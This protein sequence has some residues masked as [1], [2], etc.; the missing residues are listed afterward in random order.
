[1]LFVV[2]ITAIF[3]Q[4]I[5]IEAWEGTDQVCIV[6]EEIGL[7]PDDLLITA[8]W[9]IGDG[10]VLS[11]PGGAWTYMTSGWFTYGYQQAAQVLR[12]DSVSWG[13]TW[14]VPSMKP[15]EITLE[16]EELTCLE[17]GSA[18]VTRVPDTDE[19]FSVLWRGD[20]AWEVAPQSVLIRYFRDEPSGLLDCSSAPWGGETIARITW[21]EAS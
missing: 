19:P 20:G 8:W 1:M 2:A 17:G 9:D 5:T 15:E 14:A 11:S 10:E 18:H 3:A 6:D 12:D 13:F 4:S 16:V 7:L 21:L